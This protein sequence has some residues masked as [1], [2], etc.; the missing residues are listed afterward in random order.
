MLLIFVKAIKTNQNKKRHLK[1]V[2]TNSINFSI[3]FDYLRILSKPQR[4]CKN[5]LHHRECVVVDL[6][7]VSINI[8]RTGLTP[9]RKIRNNYK[10]K[11][12]I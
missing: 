6:Q 1:P 3:V 8:L 12:S 10:L 5:K 4:M 2:Y 9:I 11:S 7:N